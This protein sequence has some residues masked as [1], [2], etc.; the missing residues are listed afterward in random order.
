MSKFSISSDL[1]CVYL[2]DVV[3]TRVIFDKNVSPIRLI[4]PTAHEMIH[5]DN[6]ERGSLCDNWWWEFENHEFNIFD[7]IIIII[8]FKLFT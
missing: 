2:T 6:Q 5:L 1:T 3:W 4:R 7:I 8:P